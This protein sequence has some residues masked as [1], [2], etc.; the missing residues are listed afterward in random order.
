[1]QDKLHRKGIVFTFVLLFIGTSVLS[2]STSIAFYDDKTSSDIEPASKLSE[3]ITYNYLS[4]SDVKSALVANDDMFGMNVQYYKD[5]N[6]IWK[7][8]TKPIILNDDRIMNDKTSIITFDSN[9]LYVGGSGPGNYSSIQDAIDNASDGDTV[10]VY[11]GTYQEERI[12]IDKAIML[13]GENKSTTYIDGYYSDGI[14]ILVTSC[15]VT[16]REFTLKNC[17]HGG[18]G[19]AFYLWGNPHLENIC[20]SDCI[21]ENNDKGI[22]F[23]NI[24]NL[25]VSSCH[26]HHNPGQSI[27]GKNS[28]NIIVN[29]CLI[30]NNGKD[31]G[32]G[33]FR[34]G[35][36]YFRS[37]ENESFSNISIFDCDIYD[38]YCWGIMFEVKESENVVIYNNDIYR[39]TWDGIYSCG[40]KNFEI[41]NNN[42]HENNYYGVIVKNSENVNI[43]KN[44]IIKNGEEDDDYLLS[45]SGI[46]LS[47]IS[48]LVLCNNTITYNIGWGIGMS[49]NSALICSNN[50][51]D[52]TYGV[53]LFNSNNNTISDNLILKSEYGILFYANSYFNIISGNLISKNINGTFISYSGRNIISG[54]TISE[55]ENG[56]YLYEVKSPNTQYICNHKIEFNNFINNNKDAV[57]RIEPD[58]L[59][60]ML[61]IFNKWNKNYWGEPRRIFKPIFGTVKIIHFPLP[62]FPWVQFD[63]HPAKEPYDIGV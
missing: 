4:I 16:I 28:S 22:Y 31:L 18:F 8:H 20:I 53:F 50:L 30:H 42:I 62:A 14:T 37:H 35:G 34:S 39:N 13:L 48:S 58:G 60:G 40:I 29:H 51:T 25:T 52:N 41:Q 11:N 9:T 23:I 46:G 5:Y 59:V 2:S 49:C 26:I 1:M 45:T 61:E 21:M 36:I 7:T 10:F 19:Q 24:S 63:W 15:D 27:N 57:F 47:S 33:W 44:H 43:Y 17:L 56:I 3:S 32:G 55:N 38:N 6:E 54:N 12:T